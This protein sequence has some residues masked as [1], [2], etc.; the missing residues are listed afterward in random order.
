ML[1]PIR[2]LMLTEILRL[3][4]ILQS[5]SS[6]RNNNENICLVTARIARDLQGNRKISEHVRFAVPWSSHFDFVCAGVAKNAP[7]CGGG[8]RWDHLPGWRHG[9]GVVLRYLLSC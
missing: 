7:L 5:G 6:T 9:L 4:L 1:I 2:I 8:H 3:R